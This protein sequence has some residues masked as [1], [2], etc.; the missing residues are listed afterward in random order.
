LD[1][2]FW[3]IADTHLS[4]GKPKDM[5]RFGEK[6]VNHI[7]RLAAAW[8][9]A[10]KPD[11]VVLLPGDV[12]WSSTSARILPDLAWLCSLPGRKVL[13][14]GNHDHWWKSAEIARKI[15]EPLGFYVVEGDSLM[16]D[17]VV[18]CGAMGH[19]A[20]QDPYFVAD[21]KKDRY[22]R[23]LI[24]LQSALESAAARRKAGQPVVV[25]THYPPFTSEGKPTAYSELIRAHRPTMCIYGHL[26]R[27][28]EWEVARN[29]VHDGVLYALVAAD[30]LDMQPLLLPL[31]AGK[32]A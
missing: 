18:I 10:I 22:Q 7:E 11:D 25:M 13:L 9:A 31:S 27:P 6:W 12:S 23:E 16:L 1:T 4:F 28:S 3:A 15:A 8:R 30:Y 20:P 2:R 24:R 17:G 26:H 19:V 32:A 14:R 5:G 21:P 29:G